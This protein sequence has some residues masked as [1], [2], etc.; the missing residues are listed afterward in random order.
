MSETEQAEWWHKQLRLGDDGEG[1]DW[2][3]EPFRNEVAI[4][5]VD[6]F[7][8]LSASSRED[9]GEEKTSFVWFLALM[10]G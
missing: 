6:E 10:H 4:R 3:L 2:Y 5:V 1:R 9:A 7:L 8:W